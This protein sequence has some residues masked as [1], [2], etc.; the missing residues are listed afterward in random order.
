MHTAAIKRLAVGRQERF[1]ATCSHDKSVLVWDLASG[2]LQRRIRLPAGL[3][4]EGMAYAVALSPDGETIAVGGWTSKTGLD[5]F[6]YLYQRRSGKMRYTI[7]GLENVI[8]H[9]AYSPDGRTLAATLAGQNGLR[10]FNTDDHQPI[11]ADRDYGGSSYRAS[12]MGNDALVTSSYDGLIR[13]YQRHVGDWRLAD[14]ADVGGDPYGLAVHPDGTRLAVGFS[15]EIKLALLDLPGLPPL[16][17]PDTSIVSNGNVASVTWSR[18][19]D[20]LWAGGRYSADGYYPLVGWPEGGGEPVRYPVTT[21]TVMDMHPLAGGDL[22]V[23][24]TNGLTRLSPQGEI[25]WQQ[26]QPLADF[27]GQRGDTSIRVSHDGGQV[28]FGFK[29]GGGR[30]RLVGPRPDDP[31]DRSPAAAQKR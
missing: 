1:A 12:W 5:N 30:T 6:I 10:L 22:V 25:R 16:E 23:A 17:G 13:R 31:N 14:Q 4:D 2:Q 27:R 8:N 29:P 26:L 28:A 3:I 24:S 20:R 11:Y 18:K 21:N 19:G 15:D 7:A 9:L